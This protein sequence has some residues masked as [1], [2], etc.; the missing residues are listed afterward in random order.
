MCNEETESGRR[1]L[2]PSNGEQKNKTA[3]E[4]VSE[5]MDYEE[6]ELDSVADE[7]EIGN[8]VKRQSTMTSRQRTLAS[9]SGKSSAIE[10]P[11]G[12]PPTTSRSMGF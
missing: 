10:F 3:S 1:G 9:A 8:E 5:E 2:K 7:K 4:K 11:D 6:E 12:L